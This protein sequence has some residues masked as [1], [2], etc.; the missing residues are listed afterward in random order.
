M[1]KTATHPST[2]NAHSCAPPNAFHSLPLTFHL[3][4]DASLRYATPSLLTFPWLPRVN[5]LTRSDASLRIAMPIASRPRSPPGSADESARYIVWC[6]RLI[7]ADLRDRSRADVGQALP[8]P[9]WRSVSPRP[10]HEAP[11]PNLISGNVLIL[12]RPAVRAIKVAGANPPLSPRLVTSYSNAE[13]QIV[14]ASVNRLTAYG[15]RAALK[16]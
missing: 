8:R 15:A 5:V 16:S 4:K 3:A 6:S 12:A 10:I 11:A 1:L 7:W 13:T 2:P 9:T 14:R